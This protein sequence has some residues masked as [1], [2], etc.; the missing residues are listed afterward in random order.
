LLTTAA[1]LWALW[2]VR[3]LVWMMLLA[4]FFCAALEPAVR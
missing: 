4:L 2:Q 3:S 1:L